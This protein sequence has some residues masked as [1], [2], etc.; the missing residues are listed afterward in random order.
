MDHDR[1]FRVAE[2]ARS[3]QRL[4]VEDIAFLRDRVPKELPNFPRIKLPKSI[5]HPGGFPVAGASVGTFIRC[6][7][8]LAGQR[9]FGRRYAGSDFYQQVES[10]LAL[11][12][13]R[14]HFNGDAPKGAFCCK[15]CTL[16]ILPVLEANA[17]RYF[18]GRSLAKG[19]R[20]MIQKGEWR[21]ATPANAKMLQWSL[22]RS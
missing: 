2:K 18:D 19:V 22:S 4:A 1:L 3:R 17:I 12:I 15:Q 7:L 9:A 16:A 20:H 11:R 6:A 14:A 5:R 21:F 13:M 8:L 10:D